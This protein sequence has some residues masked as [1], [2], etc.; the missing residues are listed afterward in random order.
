ME[1]SMVKM[2]QRLEE[3][4]TT[5][6]ETTKTTLLQYKR[7]SLLST[8]R[9]LFTHKFDQER[10]L[11]LHLGWGTWRNYLYMHLQELST[12]QMAL[13][14]IKDQKIL[15]NTLT[16]FRHR[17]KRRAFVGWLYNSKTSRT[18]KKLM[19][20]A[21]LHQKRK[22]YLQWKDLVITSKLSIKNRNKSCSM[23]YLVLLRMKNKSMY[24]SFNKWTAWYLHSVH[25]GVRKEKENYLYNKV[26]NGLIKNT[27]TKAFRT[28]YSNAMECLHARLK[29]KKSL[30]FIMKKSLIVCFDRWKYNIQH[31]LTIKLTNRTLMKKTIGT[32][33]RVRFLKLHHYFH[34]LVLIS[35]QLHDRHVL[36]Q[37]QLLQ[38]QQLTK[39]NKRL[40]ENARIRM[41]SKQMHNSFVLWHRT[42]VEM[43]RVRAI[44]NKVLLRMTKRTLIVTF[45][46]WYYWC[47]TVVDNKN[48]LVVIKGNR[49][50]FFSTLL[51]HST[52]KNKQHSI[53]KSFNIWY[54]K[55]L[56]YF[57]TLRTM[58][59]F[60]GN[61]KNGALYWGLTQW[62]KQHQA[63]KRHDHRRNRL[64]KMI[65]KVSRSI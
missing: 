65:N 54:K 9:R 7:Q 64:E 43:K 25:A 53:R 38:A 29:M 51:N 59:R 27:L 23:I 17:N 63:L 10:V 35:S 45:D 58:K 41:F 30:L 42:V 44:T 24:I 39:R 40:L 60:V 32:L 3:R 28:W 20:K 15:Q 13:Q 18:N 34:K 55:T 33:K 22:R 49:N 48:R 14:H 1:Q 5:L 11:M 36:Q 47:Q 8:M 37:Q 21:L 62:K 19:L 57:T 56:Q 26:R 52:T 31:L 46:Q 50:L 2:Q 4:N 6:S 12:T 16:I 61:W